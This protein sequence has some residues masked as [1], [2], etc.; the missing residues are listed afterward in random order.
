MTGQQKNRTKKNIANCE[1][2]NKPFIQIALK[3]PL[4]ER[5]GFFLNWF[6]SLHSFFFF[7][8]LYLCE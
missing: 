5:I 6:S 1:H 4:E 7:W 2:R 3:K 8:F